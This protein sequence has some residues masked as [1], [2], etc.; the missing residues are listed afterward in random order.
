MV[1]GHQEELKEF[2]GQK[3]FTEYTTAILPDGA[4][5]TAKVVSR[6]AFI[7]K[8]GEAVEVSGY[9][10]TYVTKKGSAVTSMVPVGEVRR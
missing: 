6:K 2:E 10:N 4:L 5:D 7:G 8:R 9:V 3:P 1:C